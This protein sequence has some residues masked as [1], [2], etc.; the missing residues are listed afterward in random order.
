MAMNTEILLSHVG[1]TAPAK[2]GFNRRCGQII[3]IADYHNSLVGLLQF[4]ADQVCVLS[5]RQ[6]CL[7]IQRSITG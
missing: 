3:A 7:I 2:Y 4:I 5:S 1:H 6:C